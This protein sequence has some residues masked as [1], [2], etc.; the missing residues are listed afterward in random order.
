MKNFI[1]K[2]LS[3]EKEIADEKGGFILFGLFQREES[4]NIW[5]VVASSNWIGNDTKEP[6]KYIADKIQSRLTSDEMLDLSRIV[7]L[8]PSN[9]FVVDVNNEFC[10]EHRIIT[11]VEDVFNGIPM[12]KAYIITSNKGTG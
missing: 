4:V 5:D 2:F 9:R 7:L 6:L 1:K 8:E 12:K 3:I 10:T 11:S